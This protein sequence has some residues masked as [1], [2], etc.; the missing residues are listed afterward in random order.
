[1][2]KEKKIIEC[3][4]CKKKFIFYP[5]YQEG[6]VLCPFCQKESY[7]YELAPKNSL[8]GDTLDK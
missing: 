6:R 2:K 4:N 8:N 7:Y 5:S 3:P 1:M